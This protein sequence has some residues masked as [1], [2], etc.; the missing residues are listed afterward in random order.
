MSLCLHILT[1]RPLPFSPHR[2][3]LDTPPDIADPPLL[4]SQAVV[5]Y[6]YWRWARG[7]SSPC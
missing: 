7:A 1:L 2:Q 5:R 6:P 4:P 3:W